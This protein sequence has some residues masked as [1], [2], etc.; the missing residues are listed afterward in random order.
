MPLRALEMLSTE[1]REQL[2]LNFGQG[3]PPKLATLVSDQT[4]VSLFEQQVE[5]YPEAE[6]LYH[7]DSTLT[8]QALNQQANQ[9]ARCL[10]NEG[11]AE[12]E[13]VG[14]CIERCPEMVIAMLAILKVGAAYVPLEPKYPV[15]RLG[16]MIEDSGLRRVVGNEATRALINDISSATFVGVTSEALASF[17]GSNVT[18][19]RAVTI[20]HQAYVIYTSGSTGQP[21]GVMIQH[22][23]LMNLQTEMSQWTVCHCNEAW[24][25]VASFAFDASVQG[26]LQLVSGRRVVL[27]ADEEKVQVDKLIDRI[28]SQNIGVLDCTPSLAEM[29]FSSEAQGE[30]PNLVIGGEVISPRFWETLVEWQDLQGRFAWNVYGPTECTVDSTVCLI[31]GD[32]PV[33]GRAISGAKLFV[34]GTEQQLSPLGAVGELYIGGA[35]LAQGYL[36]RPDLT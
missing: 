26:L 6:A 10:L 36:N 13:L 11:V 14:I 8:Y 30:L 35:G 31:E 5:Q 27:I 16:Y 4:I 19:E 22:G 17:E 20:Q 21:K 1:E 18:A 32:E 33:I 3:T 23:S 28:R 12:G 34:L 9:L 7:Q 15:E 29:W 2:R 24:G 25:W